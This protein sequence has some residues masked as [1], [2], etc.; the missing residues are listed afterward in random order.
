MGK[1]WAG[2]WRRALAVG[3]ATAIGVALGIGQW[4]DGFSGTATAVQILSLAPLLVSVVRWGRG[5]QASRDVAEPPSVT[6]LP[7]WDAVFPDDVL[8]G[9]YAAVTRDLPGPQET[10]PARFGLPSHWRAAGPDLAGEWAGQAHPGDQEAGLSKSAA[11]GS[12]IVAEYLQLPVKRLVLLGGAGAGKTTLATRLVL[13]WH[14][15]PELSGQVPVPVRVDTWNPGRSGFKDWFCD[16]LT[17]CYAQDPAH[18]SALAA[19]YQVVPVLDGFDE[20]APDLR[21]LALEQLT[22]IGTRPLVLVSRTEEYRAA[23]QAYGRPLQAA[24][25]IVLQDLSPTEDAVAAYLH[26]GWDEVL[27]RLR[28]APHDQQVVN[29]NEALSTPMLIRLARESYQQALRINP[30][31]VN[32]KNALDEIDFSEAIRN[33]AESPSSQGYLRLGQLMQKRGQVTEARSAYE[34]ALH[35]NP[36]FDEAQKALR[37]LNSS[38]E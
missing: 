23:V 31:E 33:V 12:G 32:A 35:L 4:I 16:Q 1:Q 34:Q 10:W 22:G 9:L 36:K 27:A 30:Q 19:S 17:S 25:G 3:A 28:A 24:A 26:Q 13:D 37:A 11:G 8:R 2:G 5:N 20:L 6:P 18:S 7:A 14:N 21:R 38:S 29:L 15:F